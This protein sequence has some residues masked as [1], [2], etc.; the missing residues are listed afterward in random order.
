MTS[1]NLEICEESFLNDPF[2][3]FELTSVPNIN[4]GEKILHAWN[5]SYQ[6]SIHDYFVDKL[7]LNKNDFSILVI[8]KGH[9]FQEFATDNL[10]VHTTRI[11][12]KAVE[13]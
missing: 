13:N 8:D 7:Q 1:Y 11:I 9:Y 3:T 5:N 6:S 2:L 4:I 12:V 10:S